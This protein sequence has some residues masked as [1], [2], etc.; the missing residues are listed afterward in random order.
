MKEVM[1]KTESVDAGSREEDIAIL[2]QYAIWNPQTQD[3]ASE[4]KMCNLCT[5]PN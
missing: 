5:R 2:R 3:I 4:E 1:R